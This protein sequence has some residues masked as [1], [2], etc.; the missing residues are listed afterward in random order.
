MTTTTTIP[1]GPLARLLLRQPSTSMSIDGVAVHALLS[2]AFVVTG[3]CLIALLLLICRARHRSR[4]NSGGWLLEIALPSSV[5]K[6]GAVVFWSNLHDLLRPKWRRFWDGQPHVAFELL[7]KPELHIRI[8]GQGGVSKPIVRRAI[9]AAWPGAVVKDIDE[10]GLALP[11]S[12]LG[13]E[14][15]LQDAEWFP[16]ETDHDVDPMRMII[17]AAGALREHQGAVVQV[18]ARPVT[19]ARIAR[20]KNAAR[21]VMTGRS[22][23]RASSV[24]DALTPGVTKPQLQDPS[25]TADLQM[26]RKKS[27]GLGWEVVVRYGVF[28][29][30][31]ANSVDEL[32]GRA[33]GL[34]SAFALFSAR[35]RFARRRLRKPALTLSRRRLIRGDLLGVSE[36]AAV[37][38][39]PMDD[40]LPGVVR[41]GARS[42]APSPLVPRVGK[43]LG[44]S[45]GA[46]AR[47][48]GISPLDARYHFHVLGS[49][50]SGK[51]TLLTNLVLQDVQE[52]RGAVVIDPKGDLITDILDRIPARRAGRVVL[53]DP[54]ETIAPPTLNVL[55]GEDPDL[56]VDHLV[57]I[58]R[59]I[60]EAYWGPRTDDVLRS[61]CL[62]LLRSGK[63]TL[64]DVP[65]LLTNPSFRR[66]FTQGLTDDFGLGGF[67]NWYEAMSE[68]QQGQVI[69]PVMNKLRAFLLRPFIRNVMGSTES[70][71]DMSEVLNGGLLL[72]RVPK[73]VV[74]DETAR[75]LGSFVVAKVWQAATARSAQSASQ[76]KDASLYVDECQNFLNLPRSFDEM[77]AEARGYGLSLVLAHQ[78]L[79][80]LSR[81]LRD[82][83]SSNA[84]NKVFLSASP[85]D[86][87]Q[88]ERHISPELTAH[89]VSHLGAYQAAVRIV[90][91]GQATPAC[92]ITTRPSEPAVDGRSDLVRSMARKA[93]GRTSAQREEAQQKQIQRPSRQSSVY[94]QP[95]RL[96][97]VDRNSSKSPR[98]EVVGST[99]TEADM[100]GDEE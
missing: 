97:A 29:R 28:D 24:L 51:S 59:R 67:W 13:G 8:W 69:G 7:W 37:A 86:A 25:R 72:V 16:I 41:A 5:D 10:D 87:R 94:R 3:V 21:A 73:G 91:D 45:Q 44:D 14:L 88:L 43:V 89:D 68:A 66:P 33:H 77:L 20:C 85:E 90:R 80:Q 57:G 49:T 36:L 74:G 98:Q 84:R 83:I 19:G 92:T 95:Y 35:N 17:G 82:A 100:M 9:E 60:F 55:E 12:T 42:V 11:T 62:T 1:D 34:A 4:I 6:D 50:G 31:D 40:V 52:G 65:R 46:S 15:R 79:G 18:L 2:I 99:A 75:L 53:L 70:S 58:F 93:F 56:V 27:A 23:S 61:A 39:L 54:D 81:E 48:V 78:H 47:P 22:V 32:K 64:V 26:I 96:R 38:H 71:F 76:R 30:S 63:A